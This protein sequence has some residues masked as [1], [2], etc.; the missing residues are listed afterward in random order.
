MPLHKITIMKTIAVK[1]YRVFIWGPIVVFLTGFWLYDSAKSIKSFYDVL[2]FLFD[3]RF[4]GL[5]ILIIFAAALCYLISRLLK[6]RI[7]IESNGEM[8]YING[9]FGQKEGI[10]LSQIVNIKASH[11]FKSTNETFGFY[12]TPER[13]S[14]PFYYSVKEKAALE[15]V[16]AAANINEAGANNLSTLFLR[17]SGKECGTVT[18]R[19]KSD[20]IKDITVSGVADCFGVYELIREEVEINRRKFAAEIEEHTH[21]VSAE[22]DEWQRKSRFAVWEP[23]PAANKESEAQ[24]GKTENGSDPNNGSPAEY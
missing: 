7:L 14:T 18:L 22:A 9:A 3:D 6:P 15:A 8:L 19:L 12:E 2:D 5:I 10:L 16:N 13:Q 23:F 20:E 24:D 11:L 21:K 4:S 17:K 1:S